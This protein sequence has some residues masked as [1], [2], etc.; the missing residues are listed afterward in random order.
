[1]TRQSMA[2]TAYQVI[3]PDACEN[4]YVIQFDKEKPAMFNIISITTSFPLH[5]ALEVSACQTGAVAVFS[6]FPSP[7]TMRP[8]IICAVLKA[9]IYSI[10]RILMTVV[11]RR[12]DFFLPSISPIEKAAT[13]PKK[14][15]TSYNAVTVPRSDV[16]LSPSRP[17]RSAI[18]PKGQNKEPCL[19]QNGGIGKD[20]C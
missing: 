13:A 6:P 1:M 11:P 19:R 2:Y 20:C 10:A 12:I 4:P 7:A 16:S 5:A 17:K 14:Q 15:P 3:G 8:K 18:L 9:E